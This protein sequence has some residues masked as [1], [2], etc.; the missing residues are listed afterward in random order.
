M[1]VVG[2][3]KKFAQNTNMLLMEWRDAKAQAYFRVYPGHWVVD[4]GT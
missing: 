3:D 2:L 4:D 1:E